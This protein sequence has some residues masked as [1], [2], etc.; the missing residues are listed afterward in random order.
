MVERV[1]GRRLWR[2]R[3]ALRARD[4]LILPCQECEGGL[5]PERDFADGLTALEGAEAHLLKTPDIPPEARFVVPPDG[6][7]VG[8]LKFV[9]LPCGVATKEVEQRFRRQE[10]VRLEVFEGGGD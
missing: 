9:G 3:A 2:R 8:L 6:A 10:D 5:G 4:D 7:D 1:R